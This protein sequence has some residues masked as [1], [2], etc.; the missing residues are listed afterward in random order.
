MSMVNAK[1]VNWTQALRKGASLTYTEYALDPDNKTAFCRYF[2][3]VAFFTALLNPITSYLL[4]KFVLPSPGEGPTMKKMTTE[5]FASIYSE[6]V[7]TEGTKVESLMYFPACVGYLETA[8]MLVESGLSMA[9]SEEE[10]PSDGGG[11]FS[12]A[13]GLGNVLLHRLTKTGTYFS[14]RC[15]D[16]SESTYLQRD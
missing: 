5:S 3:L 2:G 10:L 13:F 9:L 4:F 11:F 15:K 14:V 8:R 16:S 6:G 7:G 12:P 1:V